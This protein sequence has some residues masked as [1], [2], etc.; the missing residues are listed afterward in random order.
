MRHVTLVTGPPCAGKTTYVRQ[1]AGESDIVVDL[2]LIAAELGSPK[3]WNHAP[4][5]RTRADTIARRRMRQA[6]DMADGTAW[7]VRSVPN[8]GERAR[9]AQW[10]AADR[11]LV[12]LPDTGTLTARM[13][14]RPQPGRTLRAV[15]QWTRAYSAADGDEL[16][17]G[18]GFHAPG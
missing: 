11:V 16:I 2:D 10:L 3:S 15:N 1:R 8:P 13:R 12:L 4:E 5:L 7:V 6:R 14:A 17:S 9:L 18:G